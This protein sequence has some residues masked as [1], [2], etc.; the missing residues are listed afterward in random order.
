MKHSGPALSPA[1]VKRCSASSASHPGCPSEAPA[2]GGSAK[3]A[4]FGLGE[5]FVTPSLTL[6]DLMLLPISAKTGAQEEHPRAAAGRGGSLRSHCGPSALFLPG[7]THPTSQPLHFPASLAVSCWQKEAR[8]RE[9]SRPKIRTQTGNKSR[10]TS[11]APGRSLTQTQ[12]KANV[13]LPRCFGKAEAIP[14]RQH[15]PI[16]QAATYILATYSGKATTKDSSPAPCPTPR[17]CLLSAG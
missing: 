15:E 9:D 17:R 8:Q 13:F 16:V 14:Q 7:G 6:R 4:A 2:D 1:P 5:E 11:C 10:G 12:G 3:P